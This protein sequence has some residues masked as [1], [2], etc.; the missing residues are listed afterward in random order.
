MCPRAARSSSRSAPT[1]CRAGPAAAAGQRLAFDPVTR[2]WGQS[3]VIRTS[4]WP[5]GAVV[6]GEESSDCARTVNS[7]RDLQCCCRH[8]D[9]RHGRRRAAQRL[10]GPAARG[11]RV[12]RR[13]IG[14][15]ERPCQVMVAGLEWLESGRGWLPPPRQVASHGQQRRQRRRVTAACQACA[16]ARKW[17]HQVPHA[18]GRWPSAVE[19]GCAAVPLQAPDASHWMPSGR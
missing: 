4:F 12:H 8:G 19:P 16:T 2:P 17:F 13:P 1:W 9:P 11:R 10:V 7:V 18:T 15:A 3:K 14:P 6:G 5:D